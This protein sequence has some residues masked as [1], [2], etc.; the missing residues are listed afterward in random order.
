MSKIFYDH[1]V[2]R[3]EITAILDAHKLTLDEREELIQVVDEHLH[4][5]MLDVIL[6]NLPVEKH[7]EFLG[8]FHASPGDEKLLEYLRK[9][10]KK[11]IEKEIA[12]AAKTVK[13]EIL[14]EIKK[15]KK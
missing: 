5:H 13:Q 10:S 1:L 15:A 2:Y 9:E 12:E 11:D 8:K 7:E 3:E 4:H 6:Q 14:E